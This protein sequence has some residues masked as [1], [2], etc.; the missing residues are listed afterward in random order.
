MG[1]NKAMA[2]GP[3]IPGMA[4]TS[5]PMVT[6]RRRNIRLAGVT[7]SSNPAIIISMGF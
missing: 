3:L 2:I 7:E 1:I 4:P 5:T 6:P